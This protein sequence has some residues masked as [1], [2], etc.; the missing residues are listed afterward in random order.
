MKNLYYCQSIAEID[1]ISQKEFNQPSIILMEQAGLK[2]WQFIKTK[3]N[4]KDNILILAGGGNNGGD[5]L[6]V[7]R[8]ALNDGYKNIKILFCSS[9]F[10]ENTKI[11]KK[12]IESYKVEIFN[13]FDIKE[14]ELDELLKSFNVIVDGITGIGLKN[15]LRENIES[16]INKINN[17][18]YKV[19]S[20]DTP[21]GLSDSINGISIHSDYTI[22]MGP[23]KFMY[24][25]YKNIIHCGQIHLV[26]PSFPLEAIKREKVIGYLDTK[27]KLKIKPLEINDYKK[28]RGHLAV[29]GGSNKYP[30]AIR[31]ASRAA[32]YSR[33]GL[34]SS[35]CD[36]CIFNIVASESPSVIVAKNEDYNRNN[37]FNSILVGPGWSDNREVLLE[38]ILKSN[39]PMVIDADGIRAFSNLYKENKIKI[40]NSN[41]IF[42]PHL[43]E[44]KV[45]LDAV[46]INYEIDNTINFIESLNKLS[47]E[48]NSIIVCKSSITYVFAPNKVPFVFSKLNPSL[49][50]A[51]SGD[52]LAGCIAALLARTQNPY[53][54]AIEGVKIHSKAG[55]LA[56]K[57]LGFFTSEDLIKYIGKQLI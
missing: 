5:S 13:L 34:V 11:Q 37:Q 24:Y 19:F 43:G 18:S 12:I 22:S 28:T 35:F 40:G 55:I 39:K 27:L 49:G 10:S 38:S 45:L 48:L 46:L 14:N 56:N 30:G 54:S 4:K 7:A 47:V 53:F 57:E 33:C 31:L 32:F 20:I 16:L 9:K 50:V 15:K 42:T 23:N 1:E 51:G 36:E 25:F 44:L 3:I 21:S 6:V 41:L 17:N 8:C 52:V 26:N 29:F 2:A